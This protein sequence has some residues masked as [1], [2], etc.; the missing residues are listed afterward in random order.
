[1]LD[2]FLNIPPTRIPEPQ[3]KGDQPERMLEQLLPQ[4]DT[5]QQ[6]TEAAELV[7]RYLCEGG[8]ERH[9]LAQLGQALLREDR[10]F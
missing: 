8:D 4:L 2:R 6:V 10:D 7:A 3:P 9:L 1:Y 5:Q